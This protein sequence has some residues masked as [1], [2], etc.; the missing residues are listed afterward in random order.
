MFKRVLTKVFVVTT[1]C[2][3]T[4]I[5]SS[6]LGVAILENAHGINQLSQNIGT[7]HIGLI[8]WRYSIMAVFIIFYPKLANA[9]FPKSHDTNV[10]TYEKYTR[11]IYAILF[12]VFYETI[13][14]H[15]SFAWVINK[16]LGF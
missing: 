3:I 12:C 14:V 4:L 8:V 10:T 9:F 16:L 7:H 1:V 15:N 5:M 11:R 13:L 6:F 2:I